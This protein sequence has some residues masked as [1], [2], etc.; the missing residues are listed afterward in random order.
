MHPTYDQSGYTDEEGFPNAGSRNAALNDAGDDTTGAGHTREKSKYE[1]QFPPV[2]RPP[3]CVCVGGHLSCRWRKTDGTRQ[4]DRCDSDM[5]QRSL[6][7]YV[8]E[9]GLHIGNLCCILLNLHDRDHEELALDA[10]AA[11]LFSLA[12]FS[13]LA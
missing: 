2:L 5:A 10:F 13:L 7:R 3:K 12:S 11:A 6:W 9:G 4:V 1:E 8:D